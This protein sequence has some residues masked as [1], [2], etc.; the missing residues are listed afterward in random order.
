M[1]RTEAVATERLWTGIVHTAAGCFSGW[2]HHG[3][4]ES[5]IYVAAGGLRL[6]SGAAGCD[7]L[8]AGPGDF[9]FIPP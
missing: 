4:H 9:V 8:D 6:E 1:R 2:H 3:E 7:V 5:V